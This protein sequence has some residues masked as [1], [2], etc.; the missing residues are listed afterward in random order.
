MD[1]RCDN[2]FEVLKEEFEREIW[3]FRWL[4]II[5]LIAIIYGAYFHHPDMIGFGIISALVSIVGVG[6]TRYGRRAVERAA[7][8]CL[9]RRHRDNDIDADAA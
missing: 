7:K 1:E 4:W 5:N 2:Q 3:T 6:R 8:I 9:P